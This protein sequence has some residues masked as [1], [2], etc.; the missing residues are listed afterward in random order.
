MSVNRDVFNGGNENSLFMGRVELK[1]IRHGNGGHLFYLC[2]EVFEF[3]KD[4]I[5]FNG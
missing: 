1:L 2:K 4:P 3:V 5:L